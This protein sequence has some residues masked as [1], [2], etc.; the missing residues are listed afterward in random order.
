MEFLV[1]FT[2]AFG[3]WWDSLDKDEKTDITAYVEL[4]QQMG[5]TLKH[6]YS[7]GIKGSHYAHMRELRVQHQGRPYRI[8]YAFDP[9]RIAILLIGG[10]KTGNDRWYQTF[11]PIADKLYKQHLEALTQQ[12]KGARPKKGKRPWLDRLMN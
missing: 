7:S 3:D 1:E 12:D 4:L 5:P 9:K 2:Y 11:V 8:L 10:D 6:P